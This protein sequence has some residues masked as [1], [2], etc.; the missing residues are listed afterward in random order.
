MDI[1]VSIAKTGGADVLDVLPHTPLAPG[2]EEIRIRHHAIGVNFVDIY[3]R[4]GLYPL[5]AYPAILGVEGAGIVEA[6]GSKVAHVKVGDRVGYAGLPVGGYASTRLLPGWRAIPLPDSVGFDTAAAS[7]LRGLTVHMLVN[8]IFGLKSGQSLLVHAVAG[9]LGQYVTRWAKHAGATVIGTVSN[10]EKAAVARAAGADHVIVGRETD[11]VAET[12]KATDGK[13]VEFIVDGVG[14]EKLI[15]NFNALRPFGIVASVGQAGG[16]IPPIPAQALSPRSAS[17]SRPSVMAYISDPDVYRTAARDVL[18]MM[19]LGIS[20]SIGAR[21]P[22][23][24]ARRAQAD[25]EAGK[26]AGSP[27]LVP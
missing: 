5:P 4:T 1:Q 22:L 17:L 9:G 11:F 6:V 19:G 25:L 13:G 26:T 8:R 18:A 27:L 21:Y 12:L 14:G 2:D 16:P 15:N 24:E 7:F 20:A 10:T 23:A 3:H